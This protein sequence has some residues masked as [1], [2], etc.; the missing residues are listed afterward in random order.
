MSAAEAG[1]AP[2]SSNL[3][4]GLPPAAPMSPDGSQHRSAPRPMA[5]RPRTGIASERH[6][7]ALCLSARQGAPLGDLSRCKISSGRRGARPHTARQC[8]RVTDAAEISRQRDPTRGV[9]HTT[10]W[11]GTSTRRR[12]EGNSKGR[13][14]P[15][16]AATNSSAQSVRDLLYNRPTSA[17][18]RRPARRGNLPDHHSAF[19]IPCARASVPGNDL[20]HSALEVTASASRKRP[21]GV[22]RNPSPRHTRDLARHSTTRARAAST[23]EA[24]GCTYTPPLTSRMAVTPLPAKKDE[25]AP[26]KEPTHGGGGSTAGSRLEVRSW[27]KLHPHGDVYSPRTGHTV[28]SKGT[29]AA[30]QRQMAWN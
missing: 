29:G 7:R 3:W 9:A 8:A 17:H 10:S 18:S 24:L 23:P 11:R 26:H 20:A 15:E 27:E 21:P 16:A 13:K 4:T 1:V 28:T 19:R 6:R 2:A 14:K 22:E 25:R 30:E 5:S 12:S